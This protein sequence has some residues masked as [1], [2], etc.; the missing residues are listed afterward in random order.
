MLLAGGRLVARGPVL[1]VIAQYLQDEH[2]VLG[3][4]VQYEPGE[5]ATDAASLRTI[6]L[7]DRDGR[8]RSEFANDEAVIVE[9][10]VES[11]PAHFVQVGIEVQDHHATTVFRT[12]TNDVVDQTALFRESGGLC[13]A[14]CEIPGGL[15]NAGQYRVRPLLKSQTDAPPVIADRTPVL[16][17]EFDVPNKSLVVGNRIGVVAPIIPWTIEP[18]PV[19]ETAGRRGESAVVPV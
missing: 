7:V 10:E 1:D 14:R 17:V 9:V 18:L 4:E 6:R 13:I 5:A 16:R 8:P 12:V 15:F 11:A 19:P 2:S 3:S